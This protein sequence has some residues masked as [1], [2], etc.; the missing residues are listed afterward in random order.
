M[1]AERIGRYI[2]VFR[3][4]YRQEWLDLAEVARAHR[5]PDGRGQVVVDVDLRGGRT[6]RFFDREAI[7][8]WDLIDAYLRAPDG[9]PP[10]V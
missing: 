2:R 3:G 7:E 5:E 10:A 6:T 8:A 4:D 1:G 9:S